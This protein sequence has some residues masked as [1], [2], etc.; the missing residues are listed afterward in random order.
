MNIQTFAVL[1][2][3]HPDTSVIE[4]SIIQAVLSPV[5]LVN[6]SK[7]MLVVAHDS[8]LVCENYESFHNAWEEIAAGAIYDEWT[9]L[10]VKDTDAAFGFGGRRIFREFARNILDSNE[11]GSR[12]LHLTCSCLT[13]I[14]RLK[15]S[16]GH[17]LVR[18]SKRSRNKCIEYRIS[19]TRTWIRGESRPPSPTIFHRL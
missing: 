5:K 8:T 7:T 1:R 14:G 13:M 4:Q 12:S 19:L 2:E 9:V 15:I 11:I 18:N 10:F 17:H 3:D 6:A 16:S